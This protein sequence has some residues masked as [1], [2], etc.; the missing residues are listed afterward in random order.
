[1][2]KNRIER[3]GSFSLTIYFCFDILKKNF[4]RNHYEAEGLHQLG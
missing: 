1:M 4:R 3:S 2:R